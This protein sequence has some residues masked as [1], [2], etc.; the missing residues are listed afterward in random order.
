MWLEEH[1]HLMFVFHEPFVYLVRTNSVNEA[2]ASL[3]SVY[4]YCFEYCLCFEVT[5]GMLI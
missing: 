2:Q 5:L 4:S 1:G 3:N